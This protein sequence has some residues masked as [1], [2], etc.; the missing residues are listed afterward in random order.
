M[1]RGVNKEKFLVDGNKPS[2]I[3]LYLLKLVNLT[4]IFHGEEDE[5]YG[6]LLS[7]LGFERKPGAW[8]SRA[9]ARVILVAHLDTVELEQATR[10]QVEGGILRGEDGGLRLDERARVALVLYLSPLL[11]KIEFALFL[12]EEKGCLGAQDALAANVFPN[13]QAMISLDRKGQ[14]EI[15]Y[16]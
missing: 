13:A 9:E 8:V 7:A 11:P 15:I 12:G 5:A 16:V 10:I 2:E 14:D 3:L 1:V 4:P 6:Q